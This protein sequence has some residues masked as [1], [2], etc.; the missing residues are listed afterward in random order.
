MAL[1]K[2][3]NQAAARRLAIQEKKAQSQQR[4]NWLNRAWQWTVHGGWK[5]LVSDTAFGACL[6]VSA[7][8]CVIVGGV[9]AGLYFASDVHDYGY[10]TWKPYE[11][12]GLNLAFTAIGGYAGKAVTV[13]AKEGGLALRRGWDIPAWSRRWESSDGWDMARKKPINWGLTVRKVD[14]YKGI[15]FN[16]SVGLSGCYITFGCS[17]IP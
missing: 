9:A 3:A 14:T 17:L 11:N 13:P 4:G 1:L 6:V 2:A 12:F 10:R 8:A 7:G 15:F 5:T 16:G